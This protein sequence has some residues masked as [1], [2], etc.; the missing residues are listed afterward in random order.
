[1]LAYVPSFGSNS[2]GSPDFLTYPFPKACQ[3]H[4]LGTWVRRCLGVACSASG[5]KAA[6]P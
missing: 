2:G 1:M 4:G 6:R 3:R 5:L